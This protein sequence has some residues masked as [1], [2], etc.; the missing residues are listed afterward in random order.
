MTLHTWLLYT[1]AVFILTMTPGPTVL[2]CM[3]NAVNHGA[4]RTFFAAVGSIT[5]VLAIMSCSSI[6]LV[7]ALASSQSLFLAIKWFGV[8]YLFYLGF[9]TFLSDTTSFSLPT[10]VTPNISRTSLYMKGLLVGISNPKALLF[11]TAFLP[12]FINPM[13]AQLP[14]LLILGATFVCLELCWLMFY[15]CFAAQISPWL[16]NTGRARLFNRLSGLTFMLASVMLASLQRA[17]KQN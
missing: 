2:M 11:F 3:T 14:Q 16:R 12:Q 9:S 5:G 6:G 7:A 17:V 4:R 13:A 1:L 8:A 15:A 10:A